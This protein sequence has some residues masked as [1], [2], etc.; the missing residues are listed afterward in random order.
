MYGNLFQH[1]DYDVVLCRTIGTKGTER[2]HSLVAFVEWTRANGATASGPGVK[3]SPV[4]SCGHTNCVHLIKA[5][6]LS[7]NK[8]KY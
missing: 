5:K 3:R 8:L 2:S 7:F 1:S 6:K 4:C